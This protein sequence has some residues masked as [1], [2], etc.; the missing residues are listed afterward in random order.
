VEET[1]DVGTASKFMADEAA[2]D[3]DEKLKVVG[4]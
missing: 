1:F 2:L 4:R 3:G